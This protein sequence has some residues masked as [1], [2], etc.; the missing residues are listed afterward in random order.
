MNFSLF[1][2]YDLNG[3]FCYFL[4]LLSPSI[5]PK[6]TIDK[7]KRRLA[8]QAAESML[9]PIETQLFI[10]KSHNKDDVVGQAITFLT[11]VAQSERN[12]EIRV[13]KKYI[14]EIKANPMIANILKNP[15]IYRDDLTNLISDLENFSDNPNNQDLKDFYSKLTLLINSIRNSIESFKSRLN[16]LLDINRSTTSDIRSDFFAT[17]VAGDIDTLM[18]NLTGTV[19]REKESALSTRIVKLLTEHISKI[20]LSS[21]LFLETPTE[22]LIAIMIDFEKFLQTRYDQL[23]LNNIL[24]LEEMDIDTIFQEYINLQDSF[25]EKLKQNNQEIKTTLDTI[26]TEMGIRELKKNEEECKERDKVLSYLQSTRSKK[27]SINPQTRQ[28]INKVLKANGRQEISNYLRWNVTTNNNNRHGAVYELILPVI[29]QAL[30][31]GGH[32]A[33]DV[34]TIDIGTID[35]DIDIRNAITE[36]ATSIRSIIEEQAKLQRKDR[37]DDLIDQ[38]KLMNTNIQ[39]AISEINKLL[40]QN[41]IPED[42]FIYHQSLKLYTQIEEHKTAQFHG[43]EMQAFNMMDNLY[44]L[45]DDVTLMDKDILYGALLNL[46]DLAIGHEQKGLIENYLSIFA[47]LLMFDDVQTMAWDIARTTSHEV[48]KNGAAF[49][50]HLYLVNDLYVP[51]SLILTSISQA[52]QA[53][54]QQIS[55]V[56][57]AKITIDTA[58]ANKVIQGWLDARDSGTAYTDNLS[59][60][61]V[62]EGVSAGTKM[63]ITFLSSFFSFLKDIQNYIGQ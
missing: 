63:Q 4:D 14:Q 54:Y 12:K 27:H 3:R 55:S 29:E 8:Y 2:Q 16:Q 48:S 5:P 11:Q 46:A 26:H 33:T 56:N 53:G 42:I 17:R 61:E 21:Q 58:G 19:Q 1:D 31:V 51:G 24:K 15:N 57:G 32:A 23:G 39:A 47:G 28:A 52:L 7:V 10:D 9:E 62:A 40:E 41:K 30:K 49:N 60:E 59:W 44:S 43:R 34:I 38:A 50:V 18:K 22:A 36:Q 35:I 20:N 6:P 45:E 37:Q 25:L 13:I